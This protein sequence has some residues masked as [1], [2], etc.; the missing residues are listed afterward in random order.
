MGVRLK[1]WKRWFFLDCRLA[2]FARHAV[3][4]GVFQVLVGG[5]FLILDVW[6]A[7][8]LASGRIDAHKIGFGFLL[9]VGICW[10][11]F[12]LIGDGVPVSIADV[13]KY[14][15]TLENLLISVGAI[16]T[17]KMNRFH[18]KAQSLPKNNIFKA[19]THPETQMKVIL[20]E[21]IRFLITQE[22][23]LNTESVDATVVCRDR[24]GHWKCLVESGI[25]SAVEVARLAGNESSTFQRAIATG[26]TAFYADKRLASNSEHYVKSGRDKAENTVGSICCI[27]IILNNFLK[28]GRTDI[29]CVSFASYGLQFCESDDE[30]SKKAF[31][32]VCDEFAQRVKLEFM[33]Y[34]IKQEAATKSN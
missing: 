28:E 13:G 20:Q 16:I 27:P 10:S 22:P 26:K 32:F 7:E 8:A 3:W 34:L 1:A 23:A 25:T 18:D 6:S 2:K 17:A 24:N 4:Y 5:Y 11:I 12:R 33:L 21:A 31:M 14:V 15:K 9:G 19:I 29:C 30:A